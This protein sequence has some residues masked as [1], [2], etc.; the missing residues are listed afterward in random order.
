MSLRH[1]VPWKGAAPAPLAERDPF[2]A[3]QHEINRTFDVFF[4][5]QDPLGWANSAG[6]YP[7]VDVSETN[8]AVHL[9]AELPGMSES[10]IDVELLDDTVKIRGEKK[11]ERTTSDHNVH[12]TERMFGHFERVV[13]LPKPVHR[14]GVSA[15]FKNGVLNVVLPKAQPAPTTQKITVQAG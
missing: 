3:L 2:S 5:G 9:T 6:L 14:E 15:T 8:E 12:R 10:D 7:Q 1:L 4:R 11:D 13:P